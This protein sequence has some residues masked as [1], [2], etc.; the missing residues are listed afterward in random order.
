MPFKRR[1]SS[2]VL[3]FVLW[4]VSETRGLFLVN[5][6]YS[7][8]DTAIGRIM[9]VMVL[10]KP[11]HFVSFCVS[12]C[13]WKI[14]AAI[15]AHNWEKQSQRHGSAYDYDGAWI[16]RFVVQTLL[17]LATPLHPRLSTNSTSAVAVA[18]AH[19]CSKIA[20]FAKILDFLDFFL[21][22]LKRSSCGASMI[23]ASGVG[24]SSLLSL[25]SVL[26][27]SDTSM[28]ELLQL[29]D[30]SDSDRTSSCNESS[31]ATSKLLEFFFAE[32]DLG[33][34][35]I[36]PSSASIQYMSNSW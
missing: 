31:G 8:Y 2:L 1:V 19:S 30:L 35:W 20:R 22:E 12:N 21:E 32:L 4:L 9:M 26:T 18:A 29:S 13:P 28:G 27:Y 34:S 10:T 23:S 14:V 11:W 16:I 15:Q 24:V 36:V 3:G 5:R 6:C 25:T 33:S 17:P 7:C